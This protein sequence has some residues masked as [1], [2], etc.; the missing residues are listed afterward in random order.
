MYGTRTTYRL[1]RHCPWERWH[2]AMQRLDRTW[3]NM[4]KI[5]LREKSSQRG[6][7]QTSCAY[8]LLRVI[9]LNVI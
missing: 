5:Q 9:L 7:H 8:G 1:C 6:R 4:A 2:Q 3:W